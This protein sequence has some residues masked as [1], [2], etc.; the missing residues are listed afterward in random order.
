[1]KSGARLTEKVGIPKDSLAE[2]C[3]DSSLVSGV[4]LVMDSTEATCCF[5]LALNDE[6]C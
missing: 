4:N 2:H 5:F 1:M 3:S 6:P